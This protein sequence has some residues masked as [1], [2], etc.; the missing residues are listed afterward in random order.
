MTLCWGQ[1]GDASWDVMGG[2]VAP[3]LRPCNNED[4]KCVT[5]HTSIVAYN[6]PC[7]SLQ[8]L[9]HMS[10]T[11][12]F[13]KWQLQYVAILGLRSILESLCAAE[14]DSRGL[15]ML[16]G[17]FFD[18][19]PWESFVNKAMSNTEINQR[20]L[21]A[22]SWNHQQ[23]MYE[24]RVKFLWDCAPGP[25]VFGPVPLRPPALWPSAG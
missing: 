24:S 17:P 10:H 1:A 19:Q 3:V 12:R 23:D 14:G 15:V 25:Y 5:G 18:G 16:T 21:C 11:Y 2:V 6:K 9:A 7:V 4:I 22:Q 8:Y 20:K 13:W